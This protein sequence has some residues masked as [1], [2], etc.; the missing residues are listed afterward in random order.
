ML[1]S[2]FLHLLTVFMGFFAIMNPIANTP[3]FLSLTADDS[4][5]TTRKIAFRS[6]MLAFFIVVLFAIL[7][8]LIFQVF[9]ISLPAFQITGGLIVLLIGYHMLQGNASSVHSLNESDQ[10]SAIES[11]L[12][13][14]VSPLAMPLLAGPGTIAT[15]MNFSASGS[16]LEMLVT[17]GAFAALC[18]LTYF[19]FIFGERFVTFIGAGALSVITRMMGLI[20][21]VIGVQMLIGGIHAAF[22]VN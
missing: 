22:P 10:Q 17:I 4:E 11:K 21:A 19:I 5:S 1:D 18:V 7:G 13:V 6:L 16:P 3:I 8:K 12:S 15:A 2:V 20:L 9:G 14:A